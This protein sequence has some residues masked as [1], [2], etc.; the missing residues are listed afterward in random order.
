MKYV[1]IAILFLTVIVSN[2]QND[3]CLNA[4]VLTKNS[5]NHKGIFV[6]SSW[7]GIT[8]A[9]S[10]TGYALTNSYEE[11]QFYMMNGAW[12]IINLGIALPALLSKPKAYSSLY[13]TQKDQTK[14]EKIFLAN[15]LLDVV[16]ITGGVALYQYAENQTDRKQQQFRGY[17]NAIILQGAGLLIFDTAMTLL[18]NKNRKQRLDNILKNARISFTGNTVKLGYTFN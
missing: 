13:Q 3:S 17:G 10:A 11:K 16:Y 4:F 18:N 1:I 14:T 15:A 9:G 7:A 6:L 2:A 5:L 8:I 12:G